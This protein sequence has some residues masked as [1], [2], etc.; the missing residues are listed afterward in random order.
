[1]QQEH[2]ERMILGWIISQDFKMHNLQD[3]E[4]T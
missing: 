3:F 2:L 1:M 4:F